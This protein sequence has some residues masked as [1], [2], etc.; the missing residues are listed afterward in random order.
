MIIWYSFWDTGIVTKDSVCHKLKD[1]CL[2]TPKI[3]LHRQSSCGETSL[4]SIFQVFRIKMPSALG[5]RYC[6][7]GMVRIKCSIR[8]HTRQENTNIVFI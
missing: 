6:H 5:A 2:G 8:Q 4:Q 3:I 7:S 1:I